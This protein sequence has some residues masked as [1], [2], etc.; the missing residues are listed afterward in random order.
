MKLDVLLDNRGQGVLWNAVDRHWPSSMS[1]S[2]WN[3]YSW[4]SRS[5]LSFQPRCSLWGG[6]SELSNDITPNIVWMTPQVWA[7]SCSSCPCKCFSS[8]KIALKETGLSTDSQICLKLSCLSM[9]S[10]LSPES[11][12]QSLNCFFFLDSLF[13]SWVPE[14]SRHFIS[15]LSLSCLH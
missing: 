3:I 5:S 14:G 7:G 2:K 11:G 10:P 12:L 9:T 15:L 13:Q 1:D 8:Q 6:T 4:A